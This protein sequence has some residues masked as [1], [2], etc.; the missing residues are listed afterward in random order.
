[1]TTRNIEHRRGCWYVKVFRL[2]VCH[3][4]SATTLRGA[5]RLRDAIE[6]AHPRNP[7]KGCKVDRPRTC[8]V[9]RAERRAR[10]QCI[11][12]GERTGKYATCKGC[13]AV[14]K[15]KRRAA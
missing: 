9:I 15:I 11:Y 10:H 4:A 14:S 5:I 12:C 8:A 2:R 3:Y 7:I 13:R 6:L 1:M